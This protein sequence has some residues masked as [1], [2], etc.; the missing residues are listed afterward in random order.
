MNLE[1]LNLV[2]KHFSIE[3]AN[4]RNMSSFSIGVN[5]GDGS[6]KIDDII[7][8][9]EDNGC[10]DAYFDIMIWLDYVDEFR[11]VLEELKRLV[12]EYK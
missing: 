7:H 5:S 3:K 11:L 9:I 4:G 6:H 10:I 1:K 12:K 2:I 8:I